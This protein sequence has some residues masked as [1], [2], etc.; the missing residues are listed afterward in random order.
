MRL[1]IALRDDIQWAIHTC[2]AYALLPVA[3]T[4]TTTSI[5][6]YVTDSLWAYRRRLHIIYAQRYLHVKV[7]LLYRPNRY[8]ADVSLYRPNDHYS[9]YNTQ[10]LVVYLKHSHGIVIIV[11]TI[12]IEYVTSIST[13]RCVSFSHN[14]L[15]NFFS[16][17]FLYGKE[18]EEET[19]RYY[20][21][22]SSCFS[23][24]WLI[25]F[26][27]AGALYPQRHTQSRVYS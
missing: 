22:A 3:T 24:F 15:R 18:G 14:A 7:L 27:H 23:S 13:S 26:D 16:P 19:K 10:K 17:V 21:D 5:G 25:V 12:N 20:T 9:A 8:V 6:L 4:A 2:A 1:L 11:P